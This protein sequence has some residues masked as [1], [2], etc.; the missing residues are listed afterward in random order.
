MN[1]H[2]TIYIIGI[3]ATLPTFFVPA[4]AKSKLIF[5]WQIGIIISWRPVSAAILH[6]GASR[7]AGVLAWWFNFANKPGIVGEVLVLHLSDV[8]LRD[9]R[10]SFLMLVGWRSVDGLCR[11]GLV[12]G[13]V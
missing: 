5:L 12:G 8:L 7:S 1:E 6:V 9:G 11:G 2:I 13:Q 10:D 4:I 3:P